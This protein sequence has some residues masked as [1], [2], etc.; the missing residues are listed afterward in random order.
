[1]LKNPKKTTCRN[2]EKAAT[3]KKVAAI[4]HVEPAFVYMVLRG[5][6]NNEAILSTYMLLQ[7]GS[8]DLLNAVKKLVPFN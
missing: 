1:M 8:N 3:V 4:H 5:D 2:P 6:R 7:E